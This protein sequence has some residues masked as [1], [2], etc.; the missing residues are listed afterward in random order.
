MWSIIRI[1]CESVC[2]GNIAVLNYFNKIIGYFI[3]IYLFLPI[4]DGS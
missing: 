4:I 3:K 1:I 2:Y